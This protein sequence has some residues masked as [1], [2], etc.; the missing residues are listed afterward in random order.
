VEKKQ[1]K[2]HNKTLNYQHLSTNTYQP[3]LINQHLSTNTYQPTLINTSQTN[4]RDEFENVFLYF[5]LLFLF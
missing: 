1:A 5:Q 4:S 2:L 3:T